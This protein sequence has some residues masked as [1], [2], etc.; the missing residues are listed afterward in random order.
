MTYELT[1]PADLVGV[2]R[3]TSEYRRTHFRVYDEDGFMSSF[4]TGPPQNA[5]LQSVTANLIEKFDGMGG[6]GY[7]SK[8]LV[9]LLGSRIVAVVRNGHGGWPEVTMFE[10]N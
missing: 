4:A 10:D 2:V 6:T 8:D 5:T 9:I 3:E 7:Q 1:S